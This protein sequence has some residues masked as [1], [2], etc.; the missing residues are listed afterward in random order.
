ML[1]QWMAGLTFA[2]SVMLSAAFSVAPMVAPAQEANAPGSEA[3]AP[4]TAPATDKPRPGTLE[5]ILRRQQGLKLD[6]ERLLR[7]PAPPAPI[8]LPPQLGTLGRQ[9]DAD[10]WRALKSG[11]YARPSSDTASGKLMQTAGEEWRRLRREVILK[12]APWLPAG[13][14]GLL[15]LFYLIRGRIR[16]RGGRSGRTIPRFSMSHRIAHWFLAS[17]FIL[18]AISGLMILIGRPVLLP[19]LGHEVHS[20]LLSAALQGHNLFGPVF[21]LALLIA[22]VRFMRGN[23]FQWADVKWILR[24]GGML[25]VHAPAHH[26]NFGEKTWYW[27]VVF[28]G[29]GMAATGLLLEFPWLVETLLYHQLA[30]I[31]HA[32]GAVVMIAV[33]LG[34]IYIGSIGMEGA[35][36]SMLK[37]EVDE[38]WAR[39]HHDLWYEQVTGKKAVHGGGGDDT[40]PPAAAAEQT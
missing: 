22:I 19:L 21:I 39:E 34:H 5:D 16:I 32:L 29:L 12:Y 7:R 13:V 4:A 20:V 1:R 18:M 24:G 8:P 27:I 33:A 31:L 40:P 15:V 30:T 38:N 37:G 17:V 28:V 9:S 3:E 2:L 11:A 14:L 6:P 35:L 26:Y 36:D 23:F 10:L 25:G